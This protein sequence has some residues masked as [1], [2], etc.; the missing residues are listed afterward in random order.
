MLK[1]IPVNLLIA[2]LGRTSKTEIVEEK[3][4][5]MF[6]THLLKKESRNSYWKDKTLMKMNTLKTS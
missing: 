1:T 5:L 3:S 2:K 4:F 6:L